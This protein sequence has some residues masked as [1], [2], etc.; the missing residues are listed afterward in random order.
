[1]NTVISPALLWIAAGL[2][3]CCAEAA[4][5]GV[6]L[7]WLGIGA[8]LAGLLLMVVEMPFV[9]QVALFAVLAGVSVFAGRALQGRRGRADPNAQG[10]DLVGEP[11]RAVS[12]D[13]AEGRVRFRDG[14]WAARC[15]TGAALPGAKLRIVGVDGNRLLV[16]ADAAP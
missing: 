8:V 1:M 9:A 5:P 16:A 7:L 2:L 4:A 15:T 10:V 6:Y 3:T 14:E 11:C 13:G 12:F